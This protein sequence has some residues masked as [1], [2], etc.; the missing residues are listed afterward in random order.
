M[1]IEN[2][3]PSN[4]GGTL[5]SEPVDL[6]ALSATARDYRI[7]LGAVL[8]A[9]LDRYER[10]PDYHFVDT[11]LSLL[12]GS[13]FPAD[14]PIRGPNVIYGWIQ[15]RGLE[16]LVGHADWLRRCRDIAPALRDRLGPRI[17]RM[18][19]EV[20]ARTESIRAA[21][22]G[23]LFFAMTADGQ[24]LAMSPDGRYVP[25]EIPPDSPA[26]VTELFY[27]KGMAAAAHFL[28]DTAALAEACD[29]YRRIDADISANRLARDQQPLDPTNAAVQAIPD[30]QGS[31][32]RMLALGAATLFLEC[33]GDAAY[34]EMGT[35]YVDYMLAHHVNTSEQPEIG[36]PF[37]G[38]EFVRA[39][40]MKPFVDEAGALLSDPGHSC[41]FVGFAAKFL[42][43]CR[44][45][46]MLSG[47]DS[48]KLAE[49]ER[50]LPG[51]LQRNFANGFSP[52]GYGIVKAY[53]L[54][55][56]KPLRTDMPWW[57]LPETMRAAAG[58]ALAADADERPKYLTIAARCSNAFVSRFLRP[59]LHLMAYQTIGEDG[60]PVET[61]PATPDADPGYHTGLSVIDYLDW[62]D[63]MA[64][65]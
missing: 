55:A 37:D 20:F 32:G 6:D 61:I 31:A 11:K 59:D 60:R 9:M 25:H 2:F 38:W 14:D 28:G 57:N 7:M 33:T 35:A 48:S 45:R 3:D 63:E 17:E 29:W 64:E 40:D 65:E 41:E 42:H 19:A 62:L 52:A 18:I 46:G 8:E 44:R 5:V 10:N 58:V 50:V 43:A 53:D 4:H 49:Y 15:G 27:V 16:A 36:L 26:N 12:D 23:R 54:I 34:V 22:G 51:M 24:P 39:A 1:A 21:N 30:R 13:D 47:V 56:R